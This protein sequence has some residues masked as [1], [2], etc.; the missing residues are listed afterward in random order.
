M[1]I[2]AKRRKS[3]ANAPVIRQLEKLSGG[4]VSIEIQPEAA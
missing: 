1:F 4:S 3:P 2:M